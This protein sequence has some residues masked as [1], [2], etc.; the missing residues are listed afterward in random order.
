MGQS[1]GTLTGGRRRRS[2]RD[3]SDNDGS[4]GWSGAN[5]ALC[6]HLASGDAE[7]RTVQA[8]QWEEDGQ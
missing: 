4:G 7:R 1:G 3:V 5:M 8:M 6:P 2:D